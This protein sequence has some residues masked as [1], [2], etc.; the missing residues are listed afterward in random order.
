[1]S[2]GG[3]GYYII[4]KPT[5]LITVTAPR[6]ILEK[7]DAYITT[8]KKSLY[9]QISIEAKIIEVQLDDASSLGIN[10]SSVLKNFEVSG[11][12][13]FGENGQIYPQ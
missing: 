12:V 8:L 1:M 13:A 2:A 9:Q 3:S 5:G 4:D 7:I 6:P 10:W 11:T